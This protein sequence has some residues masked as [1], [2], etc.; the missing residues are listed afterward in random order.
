[1]PATLS[2][3]QYQFG[4]TGIVLNSSPSIPFVDIEQ[5]SGLDNGDVRSS[6]KD[7]EGADGGFVDSAYQT[8]RTVVLEGTIYAN[9]NAFE[10]YMESLKANFAPTFLP[11]PLY[12]QTDAGPRVVYGKSQGLRYVKTNARNYGKQ[13][14]SVTILCEDSR[15]YDSTTQTVTVYTNTIV[16]EGRG[17]NKGYPFGYGAA[18]EPNSGTL[19]LPGSRTSPGQYMLYGPVVNPI[20]INDTL[21]LEWDFFIA[22]SKD[23]YLIIDPAYKTVRL[24]GG[25]SRRSSMVGRWW[26]L[27]PGTNDFRLFGTDTVTG[28]TRLV[29]NAL[30]SWR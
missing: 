18:I 9:P 2:V 21:G 26:Q 29:V 7:H 1:M 10:A 17:Y 8:L 5:V 19:I 27:Q 16:T 4:D 30:P 25:Q 12:F 24:N 20:V 22:L 3:E 23:D 28:V 14:F 13:P 6:T 11:V 15:I